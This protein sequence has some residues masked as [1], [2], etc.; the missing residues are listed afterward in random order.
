MRHWVRAAPVIALLLGGCGGSGR[1]S[2][3][4]QELSYQVQIGRINAPFA[5]PPTTVKGSEGLLSKAVRAYNHLDAPPALRP[6][7]RRLLSA[8]KK[9]LGAMRAA[10]AASAAGSPSRLQ[11]AERRGAD[12]RTSVSETLERIATKINGCRVNVA[13]C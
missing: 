1:A 5:H 6:L 2:E 12:A 10:A 8:L 3:Q 11:A 13:R 7:S 4:Q 9:E